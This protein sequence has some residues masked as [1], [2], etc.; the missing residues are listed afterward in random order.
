MAAYGLFN[1]GIVVSKVTN[2][3]TYPS[4]HQSLLKVSNRRHSRSRRLQLQHNAAAGA[5][6]A[7]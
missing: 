2:F 4:E 7:A 6:P 5:G 3:K 1:L